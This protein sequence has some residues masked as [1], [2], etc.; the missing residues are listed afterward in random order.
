MELLGDNIENIDGFMVLYVLN[1]FVEIHHYTNT[2]IIVK[3]KDNVITFID[4]TKIYNKIATNN[5]AI[6]RD[7]SSLIK[8][9][10]I[11]PIC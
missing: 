1:R 9:D 7:V 8:K 6:N 10:I 4:S 11:Q 2:F 5:S 3:A